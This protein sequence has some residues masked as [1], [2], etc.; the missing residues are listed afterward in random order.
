MEEEEEWADGE[1]AGDE[2]LVAEGGGEQTVFVDAEGEEEEKLVR[3]S[4]K[5]RRYFEKDWRIMGEW[6]VYRRQ[7]WESRWR[8]P[9]WG[10]QMVGP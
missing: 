10:L 6:F 2:E 4:V 5:V 7:V 1:D 3:N 9:P 8:R